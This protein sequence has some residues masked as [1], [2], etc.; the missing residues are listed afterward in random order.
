ME[1][2]WSDRGMFAGDPG[3]SPGRG[4][5]ARNEGITAG[6]GSCVYLSPLW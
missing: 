1:R 2:W 5:Q 6:Q 3:S 4:G